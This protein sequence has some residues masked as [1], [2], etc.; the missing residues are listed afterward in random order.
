MKV[1]YFD[2]ET[3]G[4]DPVTN[5]IVQLAM[6]LEKDGEVL[7]EKEWK[8]APL[9]VDVIEPSALKVNKL[10]VSEITAFPMPSLVIEEVKR[11]LGK[12]VDQYAKVDKLTSVAYNGKCDM[13][14]LK[15]WF[16]KVGQVTG[17]NNWF[18]SFF[19]YRLVDP[20]AIIYGMRYAGLMP[21]LKNFKLV[22]VCEHFGIDLGEAAHDALADIQATKAL[23]KRLY[24]PQT[25]LSE[26]K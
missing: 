19:N 23:L 17:K 18:G 14:F 8:V 7:A 21:E 3:T 25:V 16:E 10:T 13:D 12:A 20:L 24:E 6:I 15:S 1:C 2:V 5:G 4:L 22:T 26:G 11:F 9:A